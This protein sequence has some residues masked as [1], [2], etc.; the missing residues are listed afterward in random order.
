MEKIYRV[1]V[2]DKGRADMLEETIMDT[3][4][5]FYSKKDKFGLGMS[6]KEKD[7]IIKS[8]NDDPVFR[9]YVEQKVRDWIKKN[10]GTGKTNV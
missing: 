6:Q 2:S 7:E 9:R 10:A 5:K 3:C 1:R 4:D 8:I